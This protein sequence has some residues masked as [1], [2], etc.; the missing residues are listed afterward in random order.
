MKL[1]DLRDVFGGKIK[2]SVKGWDDAVVNFVNLFKGSF[3]EIGDKSLLGR[4]V[5]CCG[6][7]NGPTL[8]IV[9]EVAK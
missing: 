3:E 9:V 5:C 7:G 6:V 8:Y 2:V 1:R 4:K